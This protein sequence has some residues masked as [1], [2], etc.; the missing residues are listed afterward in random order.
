MKPPAAYSA[1]PVMFVELALEAF[2]DMIDILDTGIGKRSSGFPGAFAAAAN[3]DD[4]RTAVL[5]VTALAAKHEL[6]DFRDKM[7]VDVPVWLVDPGDMDST[8]RVTDKQEFHRRAYIDKDSSRVI[9]EH[10]RCLQGG[11]VMNLGCHS[12]SSGFPGAG[13]NGR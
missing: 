10:L 11:Q 4:R 3:Q 8:D 9:P 12:V 1:A 6:P 7:R 2:I 13:T 5:G